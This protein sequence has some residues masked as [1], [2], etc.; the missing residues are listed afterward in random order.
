[1]LLKQALLVAFLAASAYAQYSV[2]GMYENLPLESTT[3]EASG[4][5]SGYD[6]GDDRGFASG[7]DAVAI[8][9][10]CS[11]KEDG[12]YAIGGCSP[13]FLTCSGGIARIMDCPANLIYDH[14]IVACEYSKNVPECG[15]VPQDVTSTPSYYQT[16]QT[17]ATPETTESYAPVETT[18]AEIVS[19]P[20]E[21]TAYPYAPVTVETTTAE[22]VSS[23][24]GTT[25]YPY[26]PAVPEATTIPA[27]DVPVTRAAVERSCT[28]KADGFYSFGDCSDHYIACSNGY[29][30]P[31]QCPAQLAFDEARV[32]CDYTMNVPECQNGSGY[33]Q[34]VTDETTT[35]ASGELPYSNGYGYEETT[36]AGT[37]TAETTTVGE[38]V[39]STEGY[40]PYASAAAYVA[41]YG[42]ESTTAADVP[43]TTVEYIPEVIVTTTTPYVDETT[44][45]EYV[46]YVE[47][48]TTTVGY[49]PETTETTTVPYVE[50][51]T[52]AADVP[53]TTV[54]YVPEVTETTTTSYVEETT[55]TEYVEETT[56]SADV[57]T[58]TVGYE[59]EVLETTTVEETTT[60]ADVPT[61]TNG[62]VPEVVETTTTPY[63]EETTTT[64]YVEETTTAADV[65]TTT[66]GY[67]PEEVE[68]TTTPYVEETTTTPYVEETTTTPYVEETTTTP[69][70]EETTTEAETT[71]VSY[72]ETTTVADVP[73]TTEQTYTPSCVEGATAIEPCS[74]NYRNCVN[75]H[76]AIFICE[77][78]LFF[79]SEHGQC[80]TAD[81]IAECNRAI[82]Y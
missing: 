48:T 7:A 69:Y 74:Q 59:P 15:G 65:P 27:E 71:T 5:G 17:T 62:Y 51:T 61:T 14:R 52:T 37:T 21:T 2:A 56:T 38:D 57:P 64:Q 75:G 20:P 6:N 81:Q 29:T 35:E 45:T 44:T 49:V 42:I 9:T 43:T 32:I 4:D 28:G 80:T 70:V 79:S 33:D 72:E 25:A 8:D 34:G 63:V 53:T 26:P 77:S 10:D 76:E 13:Q 47:E 40:E 73:V 24:P 54:G 3:P 31:M 50:E 60:A 16:E 30:I 58:T 46:P 12:L 78:G 66:V 18:T 55:T 1:M 82:Q 11:T 19:S 41:P 36:T 68:T 67:V 22:V 23:P 39:P